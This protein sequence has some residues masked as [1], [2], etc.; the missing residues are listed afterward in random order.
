MLIGIDLGGTKIEGVLV[1]PNRPGESVHRLRVP[2]EAGH[3]YDHILEQVA[4]LV[5][6]LRDF[7]PRDFPHSLGIGTPGTLDPHSRLMRGSNTQCLNG[8]PLHAD[9]S[10]RLGMAVEIANDANCFALAEASWGAAA[11]FRTVFGVIMGTGCGGGYVVNGSV[12]QGCH[13]IAGEWG[14][15][16]IEP[17]GELSG[18]GTRGTVEA[19][20]AG[21]ALEKFYANASGQRLGLREIASRAPGDPAAAATLERLQE[22]FSRSL[23]GVINTF[24]PDAIV[25]G[26]G[27]G[28]LDVL[29]SDAVRE[30]IGHHIFAPRFEAALL[31]PGL[32]DSAGVFGAAMLTR[33]ARSSR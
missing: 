17:G 9:L 6:A 1:D 20:L 27:V 13:G 8:R 24:D 16:V 12:L 14:Q 15:L 28:N 23:A 25:V 30:R 18:Y 4:R 33:E 7:H 5:D 11:C 21:P 26:G 32:G 31:K 3:G 22:Y 19:Y 2:T 29:Y 10:A